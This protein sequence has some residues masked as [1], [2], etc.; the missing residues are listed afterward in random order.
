[1]KATQKP[2]NYPEVTFVFRKDRLHRPGLA[3]DMTTHH[4]LFCVWR[5]VLGI[6]I[7]WRFM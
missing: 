6:E 7:E 3:F 1:M 5:F 2:P 4:V